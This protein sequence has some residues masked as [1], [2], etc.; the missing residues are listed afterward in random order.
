[1]RS[2]TTPIIQQDTCTECGSNKILIDETTG[3]RVCQQCGIVFSTTELNTGPEWRAFDPIQRE[4]LPRVGAPSTLLIHDKGLST[5][6]GWRNKDAYGKNLK[7]EMRD[8]LYRLRKWQRRSK[9][10]DSRNRNLSNALSEMSKA[11]NKL[12][13]PKNV[14]ETSSKLYREALKHNLIRGRTIK[15]IVATCIYMACRKCE[16]IRSI[17]EV[18]QVL[19]LTKKDVA[20]NYRFLLRSLNPVIPKVDPEGYIGKLVNRLALRGSTEMLAKNILMVASEMRLT[21]GRGPAGMAAACVYI[22]TK[23]TGDFR[24]QGNVSRVAQ[25]TEVTVRNRYQELMREIDIKIMV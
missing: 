14:L 7:P 21:A 17:D 3:E 18:A 23:I 11:Q 8:K 10:S 16:I 12:N 24:T 2:L 1:L 19:D 15:S 6:I 20:R 5:T 13:L 9:V 22:S 25:V 4:K